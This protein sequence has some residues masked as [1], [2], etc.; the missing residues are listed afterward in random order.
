MNGKAII[1]IMLVVIMGV[2]IFGIVSIINVTLDNLDEQ[3]KKCGDDCKS[4]AC[5]NDS[6]STGKMFSY[7][8]IGI[9]LFSSAGIL[10]FS[11]K[12]EE[13]QEPTISAEPSQVSN[14]DEYAYG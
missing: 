9:Y 10:Y 1:G 5:T 11:F 7:A 2:V 14:T 12:K 4:K 6:S 8:L 3:C 13:E